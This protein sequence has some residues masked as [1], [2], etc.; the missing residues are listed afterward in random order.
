M[1]DKSFSCVGQKCNYS[2]SELGVESGDLLQWIGVLR[3]SI[4]INQYST[5]Y[6]Y[7]SLLYIYCY[8][9]IR[10]CTS[11]FKHLQFPKISPLDC[12]VPL[13]PLFNVHYFDFKWDLLFFLIPMI[14]IVL[15][16]MI[17]MWNPCFLPR[18]TRFRNFFSLGSLPKLSFLQVKILQFSLPFGEFLSFLFSL[19][20]IFILQRI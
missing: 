12:L 3:R 5:L 6:K 10:G 13:I 18:L 14:P 1:N 20:H 4:L 17:S 9:S 8:W 7:L 11:Y 16:K 2:S 15:E 19:W